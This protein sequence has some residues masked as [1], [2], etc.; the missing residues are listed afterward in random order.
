MVGIWGSLGTSHGLD[1]RRP[2]SVPAPLTRQECNAFEDFVSKGE[3][4]NWAF[5]AFGFGLRPIGGN[6]FSEWLIWLRSLL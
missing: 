2:S 6:T 5:R 1:G 4:L 3:R